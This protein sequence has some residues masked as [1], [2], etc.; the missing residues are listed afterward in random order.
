M[1]SD[2]F[3]HRTIQAVENETVVTNIYAGTRDNNW[4]PVMKKNRIKFLPLIKATYVDVDL[5]QKTL[6]LEEIFGEISDEHDV[7]S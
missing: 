7:K 3:D 2:G 1:L 4:Y 6:A 5:P